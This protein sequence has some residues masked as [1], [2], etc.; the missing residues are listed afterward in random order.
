MKR[1]L[2]LCGTP[3]TVVKHQG[4]NQVISGKYPT[5]KSQIVVIIKESK[6]KYG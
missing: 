6:F 4:V 1:K 2:I 3:R 5:R